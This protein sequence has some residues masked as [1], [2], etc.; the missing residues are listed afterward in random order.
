M[1]TITPVILNAEFGLL[2]SVRQLLRG[3]AIGIGLASAMV[4]LSLFAAVGA[5]ESLMEALKERSYVPGFP[6]NSTNR[7]R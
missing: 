6:P 1:S 5:L 7:P 2:W 4:A 3:I